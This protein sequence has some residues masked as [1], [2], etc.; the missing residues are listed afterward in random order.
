MNKKYKVSSEHT[1]LYQEKIIEAQSIK[2]AEN[3]YEEMIDKGDISIVDRIINIT[4][5]EI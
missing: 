5:E 1:L 4:A 3:L 2:D